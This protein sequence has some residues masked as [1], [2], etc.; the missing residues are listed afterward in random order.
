[1]IHGNTPP[2][3]FLAMPYAYSFSIDD[4]VGN[5]LE[6]G[7]GLVFAIGGNKNLPNPNPYAV[8]R[9]RPCEPR[10]RRS[11]GETFVQYGVCQGYKLGALC[12]LMEPLPSDNFVVA[13]DSYPVLV[14]LSDN[15]NKK[16][17]FIITKAPPFPAATS[18][19]QIQCESGD[20]WCAD[21][22][23]TH[24]VPADPP[25]KTFPDN[26]IE[27]GPPNAASW[28]TRSGGPR[29]LGSSLMAPAR[30]P[31][32]RTALG[33]AALRAFHQLRDGEPKVLDDPITPH[34]LGADLARAL[35][36][37]DPND[38]AAGAL[39]LQVVLRSRFAEDRLAQAVRRGVRQLVILGAGLDTFAYRQPDWA[40][41]LRIF[42]VDQPASQGDKR[43]RLK[44]A[45]I[46]PPANVSF[47]AIDFERSSLREGL[48]AS[49]LDFS[50][51][52][53]FS[54]LG[55]LVYLSKAA[56]DAVFELVASFPP[57]SEIAFTY[58]GSDAGRSASAERAAA[59]GEPWRTPLDAADLEADLRAAGFCEVTLLSPEQAEADYMA[60]PRRDGLVRPRAS[61]IGAAVVG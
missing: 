26:Y 3:S 20:K 11:T 50:A 42:E 12:P 23:Q 61:R 39:R 10:K 43:A 59:L 49:D 56:V 17:S 37:I 47:V 9:V 27:T 28:T 16:Y 25:I 57:G 34:L 35:A 58:A 21:T 46:E 44:A 30:R 60:A 36:A 32:S 40:K 51:P 4:S 38:A 2:N 13:A 29:T 55:V 15:H 54:C 6:K 52:T 14:T 8:G 5:M 33:A 31:A 53:F 41:A 18:H 7:T 48:R 22:V 1:M 24:S 19:A 45:G